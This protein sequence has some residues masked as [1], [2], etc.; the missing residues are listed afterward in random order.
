MIKTKVGTIVSD[1]MIGTAVVLITRMEQHPLYGKKYRVS[2]RFK[3]NN[4]ENKYKTGQVVT[5]KET[6]RISKDKSWEIV[7]LATSEGEK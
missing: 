5:I 1:K 3:V 6:R 7:G 2:K 4:P